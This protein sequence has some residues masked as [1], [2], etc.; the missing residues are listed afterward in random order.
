MFKK[1]LKKVVITLLVIG[2]LAGAVLGIRYLN[3]IG[4]REN[5]IQGLAEEVIENSDLALLSGSGY[6]LVDENDQ[7][8]LLVSFDDG[9]IQVVNKENGYI[10]RSAPTDE[11]MALE[12]SNTLWKNNL[13]SPV[14]F[15][16]TT[17]LSSTDTKYTN[18]YS[19]KT[20]VSVF[21]KDDGVRVYFEFTESSVTFGYDI[22]LKDDRLE[23]NIP[24]YL[25]SDPGEV[26]RTSASGKVSLDKKKSCLVAEF[27]LFPNLGATRSDMGNKG[28]ML[29][30]DGTGA[31]MY[32][33]SD[34]YAANQ[35]VAH[36][37]GADMGLYNG[38]DNQLRTELDKPVVNYPVFGMVRDGNTMLAIVD[39]G[40][41]QADIV[42]SKAK[43][44]T[45]FNTVNARFVYRMKYKV[46]TNS[47][48]GDGYLSYTN[49]AVTEPRKLIY[50]FGTGD[51]VDMANSYRGYLMDKYDLKP[52]AKKDPALQLYLVGGD[53]ESGIGGGTF[54]PMTTFDQAEEILSYFS[55]QGVEN[56]D[57]VYSGWAKHGESVSY[58][59]RFPAAGKLG[60]DGGLKDLAAA[61]DEWNA[62][63]Y[64]MDNHVS[65]SSRKGV[66]LGKNT[67]YNIQNNPLFDGAFANAD[68]IFTNYERS[69]KKYQQYGVDGL[70][71]EMV[72]RILITDYSKN[73]STSREE[74]KQAHRQLLEKMLQDFG[75]LRLSD[76]KS[77]EIM[78]GVVF[79]DL[80]TSSYL[81]IMDENVPFYPIAIHG[82]VDYLCGDYMD[83][84]EP[85][86]QLLDAVAKGGQ[87]SFT[88]SYEA[89]EKLAYA[90]SAA[91]YSTAFDLWKGDVMAVWN[92]MKEYLEKTQGQFVT[93][94]QVLA[95]GVTLTVY[96]NG[97]GVLVNNTDQPYSF[98]GE[99]VPARSFTVMEGR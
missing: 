69:L 60:G 16:Y 52:M 64:L 72:G 88:L 73:A 22:A 66:S 62:R 49:F 47:A 71:E 7:L 12:K 74:M 5:V 75:S 68:F 41:T 58:P 19:Q 44:Q 36:V 85:R 31:L 25:V 99:D 40:E 20:N 17:S 92:E 21:K 11:E 67:I 82:L 95:K 81:S 70:E 26:Y 78:D 56:M 13:R 87:V 61:A 39:Q 15:T 89:T 29:V 38:Y 8:Q 98:E 97:T 18:T 34:K 65:L 86:M 4:G 83:F 24:S 84:Y 43:V 53:V 1:L 35:Y 79:T 2:V 90:D 63:L 48:N 76:G 93:D 42:A 28:Y 54:I 33:D 46:I 91:Y 96:E 50:Y 59:D 27:Y 77:F 94:Y 51:Y 32:F 3:S 14:M 37:Y 30:P 57:A 6:Q 55:A 23:V 10:W 9:N 45:G 80:G